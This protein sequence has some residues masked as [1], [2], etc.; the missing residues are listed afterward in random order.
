MTQGIAMA[1]VMA[2]WFL[3]CRAV[4]C[5]VKCIVRIAVDGGGSVDDHMNGHG[6]QPGPAPGGS[7]GR[8]E[9]L[10]GGSRG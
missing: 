4:W 5:G 9:N 1:E 3:P 10:Q 6:E 7:A 2:M 8:S